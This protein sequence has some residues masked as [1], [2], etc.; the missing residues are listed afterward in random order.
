MG[1]PDKVLRGRP[2]EEL[3]AAIQKLKRVVLFHSKP[4][5]VQ[6]AAKYC[7]CRR[8][9]RKK[10][11]KSKDMVQCIGCWEWFHYDCCG[12]PDGADLNGVQW[13]C[14]WCNDVADKYGYQRWRTG[15]KNPK[16][17]HYKDVPK[18][19]GGVQDGVLPPAYSA[20]VSWEGKVEQVKEMARRAA[21]K[22]R[23]LT[24]AVEN[25]VEG[26]GHHL[27]DAVGMAGLSARPVDDGLIDEMLE[28]GMLEDVSDEELQ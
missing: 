25:L 24:E 11:K 2:L 27:V 13:S 15:R 22:N 18:A 7:V 16:K 3:P 5:V 9:E 19:R 17:R 21:I 12:L 4:I 14:E 10:G 23:K 6:E 1:K 20:P 28:G 8:G 26:R